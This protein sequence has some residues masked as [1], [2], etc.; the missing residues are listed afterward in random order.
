MTRFAHRIAAA[1]LLALAACGARPDLDD[2]SGQDPE[3]ELER[4]LAGKLKAHGIFQDLFG[5]VR[6]SFVADI[7]GT[8]DGTTLTLTE[9]F[10]YEDGTTEQRVWRL[11]KT[12]DETWS[13]TADGVVGIA[14][15]EERGNAFN[16][17]YT[18]DLATPDGTMRASFDDWLWQLDD[19]VIINKAYVSRYGITIG[20]LMIFFRRETPLDG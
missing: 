12:G 10:T 14:E 1:A 18:I 5:T 3:L 7:E 13:G 11:T 9:D 15:G 19:E 17:R 6:R 2:H 16:W 8:W 20:E 4:F